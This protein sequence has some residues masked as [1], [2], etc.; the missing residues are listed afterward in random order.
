MSKIVER[1]LDVFEMFAAEKRPLSL[2]DMTRLL[3]IPISSCHD[4]VH[5]LQARG[6]IYETAP[7]AGYYP[8]RRLHSISRT[9]AM[10]DSVVQRAEPLLVK[11]KDDLGETVTLAKA[12]GMQVLYLLVLEPEHPIRFSVTEGS[13]IRSLYATSAGKAFL[14]TFP[15]EA[16]KARI[17]AL[18]LKRL[19]A[20]TITSKVKLLADIAESKTRGW[21]VNREESLAGVVT[22]SGVFIWN[23]AVHLVTVA[24]PAARIEGKMKHAAQRVV[25]ACRALGDSSR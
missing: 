12:T 3:G 6:Y 24:G 21:F 19:T 25:E 23:D 22:V 5:A 8:T 2:T 14:S 11:M 20:K 1:T 4:V 13:E 17:Q 16:L 18:D 15:V 7:R 9:I 10:N